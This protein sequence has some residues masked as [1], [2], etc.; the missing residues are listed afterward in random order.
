MKHYNQERFNFELLRVWGDPAFCITL[1][2]QHGRE[3]E[4]LAELNHITH[5]LRIFHPEQ[6][7][8]ACISNWEWNRTNAIKLFKLLKEWGYL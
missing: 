5:T 3:V 2:D 6:D 1:K 8:Y 7:F 4:I